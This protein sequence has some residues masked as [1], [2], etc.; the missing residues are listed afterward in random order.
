MSRGEHPCERHLMEAGIPWLAMNLNLV[1]P[2]GGAMSPPYT[3][4][5]ETEKR[6][7][8]EARRSDVFSM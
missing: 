3:G 1:S 8:D 5:S 4:E 6:Q 2:D 7:R